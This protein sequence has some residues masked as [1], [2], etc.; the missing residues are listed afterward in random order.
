VKRGDDICLAMIP[1]DAKIRSVD[2]SSGQLVLA[3]A[4]GDEYDCDIPRVRL[5][6]EGVQKAETVQNGRGCVHHHRVWSELMHLEQSRR[7]IGRN[8]K[9]QVQSAQAARQFFGA[10]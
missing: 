9:V 10:R 4:L 2:P 5:A 1:R 8:V 6:A 7:A 3:L